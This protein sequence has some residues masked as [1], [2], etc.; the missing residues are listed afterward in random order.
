MAAPFVYVPE[1][2]A[3]AP[4]KPYYTTPQAGSA[5]AI[6]P[7][8]II[9]PSSPYVRPA[10]GADAAAR[11][12]ALAFNSNNVLW[13]DGAP[14]YEPPYTPWGLT[15]QRTKSMAGH[16]RKSKSRERGTAAVPLPSRSATSTPYLTSSVLQP[17]PSSLHIHSWLISPTFHFDL[18]PSVFALLRPGFTRPMLVGESELSQHATHPARV[19]LRILHPALPFWPVDVVHSR[20]L[21]LGDVL[22]GLHRALHQR[23]AAADWDTLSS[24]D[25]QRVEE[26]FTQRCRAEAVRSG[27]APAQLHDREV[28]SRNEGVK[29]VDFLLGKT[30]FSGL[31]RVPGDPERCFRLV[32]L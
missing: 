4:N 13:P 15:R 18:A 14:Q 7:T 5:A 1:A 25:A 22:R 24:T 6:P 16:K 17:A 26:A 11:W 10:D 23:I 32:T 30:V 28:A 27:V 12:T 8:P 2:S 19:A 31:V 9:Y 21:T 20:A 29:R 3:S